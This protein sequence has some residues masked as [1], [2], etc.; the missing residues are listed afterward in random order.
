M[1]KGVGSG[2]CSDDRENRKFW[3]KIWEL[4]TP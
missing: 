4:A 2:S 3:R 1:S